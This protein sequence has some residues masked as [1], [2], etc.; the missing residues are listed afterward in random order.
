MIVYTDSIANITAD[1][2]HGFFDSWPNSPS[3]ESH[4]KLLSNSD[5]IVLAV[6]DETGNVLQPFYARFGM[7]PASGMVVRNYE[8]QGGRGQ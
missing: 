5:E 3:P 4:L 8:R 6:D 2:L 1:N 7:K